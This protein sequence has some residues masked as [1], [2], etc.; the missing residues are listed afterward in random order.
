MPACA[1]APMT[2]PN[3]RAIRFSPE[4]SL[5]E[6]D[7]WLPH[8]DTVGADVLVDIVIGCLPRWMTARN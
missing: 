7:T 3:S 5:R 6:I 2:S 1:P 8:A 4:Q